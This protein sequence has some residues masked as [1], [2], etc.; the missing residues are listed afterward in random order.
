M[1]FDRVYNELTYSDNIGVLSFSSFRG[2]PRTSGLHYNDTPYVAALNRALQLE[3]TAVAIYA[4]KQ[5]TS[6]GSDGRAGATAMDRTD[7][8]N[9]AL[10][11][12]VQLI[13]AQRGLPSSGTS[14]LTAVTGK[15]A[16]RVSRF[17]PPVVQEPMLGVSAQRIE[18]ALARRYRQILEIAPLSDR[19]I[20]SA[21]LNEIVNFTAQT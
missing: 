13:F 15:V 2:R 19:E 6:F 18:Y 8:H 11:Q 12:L 7:F 4:V 9:K 3:H 20:I 14:G 5:R 21:L 1:P 10:R 17:M 16:A